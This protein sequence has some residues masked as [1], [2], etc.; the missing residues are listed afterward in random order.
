MAF[1]LQSVSDM[2]AVVDVSRA[3]EGKLEIMVNR[4]SV[5]NSVRSVGQG[6][7]EVSFIPRTSQPHIVNITF[8]GQPLPGKTSKSAI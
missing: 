1:V 2:C 3:G 6:I 7:F 4:G 5:P 8:N